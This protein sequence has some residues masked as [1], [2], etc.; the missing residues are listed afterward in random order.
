MLTHTTV[1]MRHMTDLQTV[2][3][4]LNNDHPKQMLL[5]I[6][7]WERSEA[8]PRHLLGMVSMYFSDLDQVDMLIESLQ[9]LKEEYGT[10]SG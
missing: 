3:V 4:N 5:K 8:Y 1:Y 6:Y 10:I 7:E 9:N 2:I